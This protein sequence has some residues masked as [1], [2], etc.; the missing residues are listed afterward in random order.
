MLPTKIFISII[1]IIVFNSYIEILFSLHYLLLE[2]QETLFTEIPSVQE[3]IQSQLN[4]EE[5]KGLI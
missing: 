1:I 3:S 5:L 2:K 4:D